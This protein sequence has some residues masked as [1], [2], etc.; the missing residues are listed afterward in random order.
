MHNFSLVILHCAFTTFVVALLAGC[1]RPSFPVPPDSY[2]LGA[3]V[4]MEKK[5]EEQARKEQKARDAAVA[6]QKTEDG[7]VTPPDEIT[8]PEMRPVGGR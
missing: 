5:K 8:L 3:R 6:K 1:G 2:G 4:Q 7:M